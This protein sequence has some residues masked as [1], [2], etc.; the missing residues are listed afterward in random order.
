M[1]DRLQSLKSDRL[2]RG[3]DA[4]NQNLTHARERIAGARDAAVSMG[5]RSGAAS[6]AGAQALAGEVRKRPVSAG[7]IVLGAAAGGALLLNPA[8]RRLAL[9]NAPRIW[10][11]VKSR[12]G[13]GPATK[14]SRLP[15]PRAELVSRRAG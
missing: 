14:T 4:M 8:L 3:S 10:R 5:R 15:F 12:I 7:L 13:T 11:A 6:A 2:L 9:A 1:I